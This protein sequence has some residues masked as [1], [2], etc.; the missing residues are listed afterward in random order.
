ML[1]DSHREMSPEGAGWG[2]LGVL[3]VMMA[4]WGNKSS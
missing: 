2:G 1:P 3:T 4:P